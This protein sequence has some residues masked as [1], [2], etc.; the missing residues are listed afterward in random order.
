M[1]T[2]TK[3]ALVA[4][5]V[6]GS[7][8]V[9]SAQGFDPNPANR[10]PAYAA[11]GGM[12]QPYIGTAVA[13]QA[14]ASQRIVSRNVSSRGELRSAPVALRSAPVALR[15]GNAARNVG[16]G[17]VYYGSQQQDGIQVDQFDHASSPYAGGVN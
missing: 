4:A 1:L 12:A 13:P 11:P 5:L 8:S 15:Q 14:T 7:A 16:Q 3:I 2:K 9:A 6:A 17:P 10:F